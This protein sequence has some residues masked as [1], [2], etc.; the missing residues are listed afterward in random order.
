MLPCVPS[1]VPVFVIV[2]ITPEEPFA[3]PNIPPDGA[4]IMPLLLIRDMVLLSLTMVSKDADSMTP[5][6][7]LLR[8]VIFN[9]D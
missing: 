5:L 4:R 6:E 3:I 1:I 9:T 2:E 7:K 8:D